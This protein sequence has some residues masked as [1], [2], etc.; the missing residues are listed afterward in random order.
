MYRR[1]HGG[2]A[3]STT[4][5][6]IENGK[7]YVVTA[8][9]KFAKSGVSGYQLATTQHGDL[10]NPDLIPVTAHTWQGDG[11][12]YGSWYPFVIGTQS[13]AEYRTNGKWFEGYVAEFRYY[14]RVLDQDELTAIQDEL[15]NKY[16]IIPMSKPA[17]LRQA[18]YCDGQGVAFGLGFEYDC[19]DRAVDPSVNDENNPADSCEAIQVRVHH[20]ASTHPRPDSPR[21]PT[22]L[23]E[24][25]QWHHVIRPDRPIKS[26][27]STRQT[28]DPDRP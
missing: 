25:R 1:G 2:T 8:Q 10:S 16:M 15:L 26:R 17:T 21:S 9:Y 27:H 22:R 23:S 6:P 20:P 18:P 5:P 28:D 7:K 24:R 12:D 13:K 3:P 4:A 19:P 11:V 14:L